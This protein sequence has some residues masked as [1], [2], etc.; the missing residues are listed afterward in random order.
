MRRL[1]L[2]VLLL[3]AFTAQAASEYPP[4]FAWRTVT[5]DH[6]LVHFHQGEDDL[7]RRA[8]TIAEQAHERLVPM[9]GWEPQEAWPTGA[10][11]FA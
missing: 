10:S 9:L 3:T 4:S 6:F 11:E 5:T 2:P 8:A 1:L 7:A